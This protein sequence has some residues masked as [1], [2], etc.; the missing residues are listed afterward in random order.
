MN[1]PEYIIPVPLHPKR[2]RQRG[3]NQAT[4]LA[5][6]LSKALALPLDKFQ[7]KRTRYTPAQS[8]L[9][10]K[11]RLKNMKNAFSCKK[12]LPYQHVAIVDDVMTTGSTL[13]TLA[14]CLKQNGVSRVDVWVI[15]RTQFD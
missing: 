12:D 9:H 6:P 5:K 3:Y 15:A 1:L 4:L 13:N 11:A 2:I 14:H 10:K 7:V 8:Q